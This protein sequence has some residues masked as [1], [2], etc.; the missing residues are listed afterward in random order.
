MILFF[1]SYTFSTGNLCIFPYAQLWLDINKFLRDA[2]WN[3]LGQGPLSKSL[4]WFYL[5]IIIFLSGEESCTLIPC[6][7]NQSNIGNNIFEVKQNCNSNGGEPKAVPFYFV[8]LP[9]QRFMQYINIGV[10]RNIV[11]IVSVGESRNLSV[12]E[13][14]YLYVFI[15]SKGKFQVLRSLSH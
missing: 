5:F 14:P 7:H 8:P 1:I 9:A 6:N 15:K 13:G 12:M 11:Y 3:I 2:H 4:L 10:T